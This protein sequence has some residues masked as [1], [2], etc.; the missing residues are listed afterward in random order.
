MSMLPQKQLTHPTH[1]TQAQVSLISGPRKTR[2]TPCKASLLTVGMS[3]KLAMAQGSRAISCTLVG[4]LPLSI[5]P[6]LTLQQPRKSSQLQRTQ[7]P[8]EA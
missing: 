5:S 4:R 8:A 3:S 2:P 7:P 1:P 6:K